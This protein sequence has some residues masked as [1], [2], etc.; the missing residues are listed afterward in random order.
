MDC[1][2]LFLSAPPRALVS[3]ASHSIRFMA[4]S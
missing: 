1:F 2:V 3:L 4:L